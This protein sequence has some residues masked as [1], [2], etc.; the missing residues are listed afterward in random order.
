M[1]PDSVALSLVLVDEFTMFTPTAGSFASHHVHLLAYDGA[2]NVLDIHFGPETSSEQQCA[3]LRAARQL[4]HSRRKAAIVLAGALLQPDPAGNLRNPLRRCSNAVVRNQHLDAQRMRHSFSTVPLYLEVTPHTMLSA[5]Q[6]EAWP[7]RPALPYNFSADDVIQRKDKYVLLSA[8]L[9]CY[10]VMSRPQNWHQPAAATAAAT[11]SSG[12][13]HNPPDVKIDCFVKAADDASWCAPAQLVLY[14]DK[15]DGAHLDSSSTSSRLND[16]AETITAAVQAV[17]FPNVYRLRAL[18]VY[19]SWYAGVLQ[20]FATHQTLLEGSVVSLA[21]ADVANY[22]TEAV[23]ILNELFAAAPLPPVHSSAAGIAAAA[24]AGAHLLTDEVFQGD[25]QLHSTALA[26]GAF[27]AAGE[28]YTVNKIKL[29]LT[30]AGQTHYVYAHEDV[31]SCLELLPANST[32][33]EADQAAQAPCGW[34]GTGDFKLQMDGEEMRIAEVLRF[35]RL[36]PS[37]RRSM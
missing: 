14:L 9:D 25:L 8:D 19:T 29:K 28:Y 35:E 24:A 12:T 16:M 15:L 6:T 20:L 18:N 11:S 36:P 30:T 17:N 5:A 31:Y 1:M 2:C 4:L 3:A 26:E 10:S 13:S 27:S 32:V 7:F 23:P 22:N 37:K 21:D 33:I 34:C